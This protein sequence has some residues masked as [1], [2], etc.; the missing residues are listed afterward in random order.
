MSVAHFQCKCIPS[1]HAKQKDLKR[2]HARD[3][4]LCCIQ[5]THA[6]TYPMNTH[7]ANSTAHTH[8]DVQ[9]MAETKG[10]REGTA[11]KHQ[12]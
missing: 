9:T 6:C 1:K 11:Q 10:R 12:E 8:K 7:I 2:V 4:G 3:A 5:C